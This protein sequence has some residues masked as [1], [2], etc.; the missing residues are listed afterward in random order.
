MFKGLSD[1]RVTLHF[2]IASPLAIY[3]EMAIDVIA[4][5]R[6]ASPPPSP[7]EDIFHLLALPRELRYY[8]A[9]PQNTLPTADHLVEGASLQLFSLFIIRSLVELEELRHAL[10]MFEI[11]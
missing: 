8:H 9:E 6:Y 5:S 2:I 10:T 3:I 7:L 1:S 4:L 11:P